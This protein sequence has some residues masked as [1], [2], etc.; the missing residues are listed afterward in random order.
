M[1][2]GFSH[3]FTFPNKMYLFPK[4]QHTCYHDTADVITTHLPSGLVCNPASVT[5][6][7]SVLESSH[8]LLLSGNSGSYVLAGLLGFL[9]VES[10][11]TGARPV[12][13]YNT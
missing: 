11:A 13:K 10:V 9:K 8:Q 4:L 5:V 7:K 2:V 3:H 12:V 1:S 6:V